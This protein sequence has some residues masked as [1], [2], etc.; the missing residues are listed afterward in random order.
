[1]KRKIILMITLFI[2]VVPNAFAKENYYTNNY[3]V[4][5]TKEEYDYI[6]YMYYDGYQE[7]FTEEDYNTLIKNV[8]LNGEKDIATYT[9]KPSISLYN[10]SHT[11]ASK[12]IKI[13]KN[14]TSSECNIAVT[15]KW[16]KEAKV[17]S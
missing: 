5:L 2:G 11:T 16:L 10:T 8:D 9:E 3:N 1:M 7:Y 12:S 4:S 15:L 14:C 13:A 6:S 17:H